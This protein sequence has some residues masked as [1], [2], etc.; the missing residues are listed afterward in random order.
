M[1]SLM[2]CRPYIGIFS[3]ERKR[4]P[5]WIDNLVPPDSE[6]EAVKDGSKGL[7]LERMCYVAITGPFPHFADGRARGAGGMRR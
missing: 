1:P 7:F 4:F 6:K 2:I 3:R 5:S